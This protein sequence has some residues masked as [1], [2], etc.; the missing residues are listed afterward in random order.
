MFPLNHQTNQAST[1]FHQYETGVRSGTIRPGVKYILCLMWQ[2]YLL[3]MNNK[4][5]PDMK[6]LKSCP[7]QTY[8]HIVNLLNLSHHV[9]SST[10]L[11]H[12]VGL[13]SAV[14]VRERIC[15]GLELKMSFRGILKSLCKTSINWI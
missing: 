5:T 9:K 15:H 1:V 8:K 11:C 14:I 13:Q 3:G 2:T 4:K 12:F 6:T 10:S 7:S